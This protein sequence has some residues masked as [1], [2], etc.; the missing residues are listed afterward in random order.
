[1]T[2][3][4]KPRRQRRPTPVPGSDDGLGVATWMAVEL[5]LAEA[6]PAARGS[7][8]TARPGQDV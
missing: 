8:G 7:R 3:L 4:L 5:G 1:M 6:E 2:S